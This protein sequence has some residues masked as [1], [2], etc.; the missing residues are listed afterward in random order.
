MSFMGGD[1]SGD[2]FIFYEYLL[3]KMEEFYRNI[4]NFSI[5]FG[6]YF[7]RHINETDYNRRSNR[8]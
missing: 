5:N 6:K 7:L 2:T 3:V 1:N 8:S 4:T